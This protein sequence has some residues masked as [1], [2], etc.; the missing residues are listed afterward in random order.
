MKRIQQVLFVVF[1]FCFCFIFKI[2]D[3][4]TEV[5][6]VPVHNN[7][8]EKGSTKNHLNRF[9]VKTMMV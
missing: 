5:N 7:W 9:T 1:Y 2:K 3:K 6:R 8:L 4:H